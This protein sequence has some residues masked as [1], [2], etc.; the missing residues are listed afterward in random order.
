MTAGMVESIQPCIRSVI[1]GYKPDINQSTEQHVCV[2][3]IIPKGITRLYPNMC[4]F[5]FAG[6]P[7]TVTHHGGKLINWCGL[8]PTVGITRGCLLEHAHSIC[9]PLTHWLRCINLRPRK[10]LTHWLECDPFPLYSQLFRLWSLLLRRPLSAVL[11]TSLTPRTPG[12]I[13]QAS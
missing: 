4:A 7:E 3:D 2:P 9:V 8:S 13:L 6:G 10:V 11:C 5:R 12:L 1:V